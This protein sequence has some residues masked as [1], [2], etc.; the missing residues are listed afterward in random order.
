MKARYASGFTVFEA[1][2][3]SALFF[4][5]LSV[6]V[7]SFMA[8]SQHY[9]KGRESIDAYHDAYTI[10]DMLAGE[11]REANPDTL[12]ITPGQVNFQKYHRPSDEMQDVQWNLDTTTHK[13][14]R[15]YSANPVGSSG[16]TEFGSN[17][18]ALGFVLTS[19]DISNIPFPTTPPTTKCLKIVKISISIQ[20]A[21][22]G[23]PGTGRH[24]VDLVS[25]VYLRQEQKVLADIY[26][27][28]P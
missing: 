26:F 15:K 18:T 9:T 11:L 22:Q 12:L 21:P 6:A 23:A 7:M 20:G 17:V 3:A 24:I 4:L 8:G 13:V 19:R 28:S 16:E 1:L 2:I 10:L 27:V 14:K 25:D 5:A